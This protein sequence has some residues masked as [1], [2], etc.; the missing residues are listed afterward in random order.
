MSANFAQK[1]ERMTVGNLDSG[2]TLAM[3]YNPSEF[4]EKVAARYTAINIEGSSY[5]P[6]QYDGTDNHAPTFELFFDA[7]ADPSTPYDIV[8]ARNF[9][10]ALC[11]KRLGFNGGASGA[12]P[13]ALFAW[14][15]FMSL[16]CKVT[17]I[18]FRTTGWFAGGKPKAFRA[19]FT[20]QEARTTQLF[21]EDVEAN[22]TLRGSLAS[23]GA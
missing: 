10:M 14:P 17:N 13:R 5:Q 3:Q 16:V 9:L 20:I 21:G 6:L 23:S 12:P 15:N 2:E 11:Y 19:A 4:R 22:G 7:L 1:P 8:N 18:E